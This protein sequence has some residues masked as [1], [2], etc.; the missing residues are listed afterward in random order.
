MVFSALTFFERARFDDQCGGR[1]GQCGAD[2]HHIAE[3]LMRIG[4]GCRQTECDDNAHKRERQP[5]PLRGVKMIAG[6][7]PA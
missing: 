6:N 2:H 5:E 4:G 3:H 1:P 7:E